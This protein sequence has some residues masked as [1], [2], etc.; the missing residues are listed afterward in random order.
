MERF[1][2][3]AQDESNC[4]GIQEHCIKYLRRHLLIGVIKK[5]KLFIT[6]HITPCSG[7]IL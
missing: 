2:W 6:Y 1:E 4:G 3:N 7:Q 5:K